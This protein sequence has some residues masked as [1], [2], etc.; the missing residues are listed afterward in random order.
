MATE[1][2]TY[3]SI[4]LFR[5]C[6]V[7]DVQGQVQSVPSVRWSRF[8]NGIPPET[9]PISPSMIGITD[10]VIRFSF[11]PFASACTNF[12]YTSSE[13]LDGEREG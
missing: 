9:S 2:V 4:K 3:P 7:V 1:L 8:V 11:T 6:V 13:N 12:S 10:V 5:A